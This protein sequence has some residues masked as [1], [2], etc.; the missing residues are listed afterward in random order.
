MDS[1][2]IAFLGMLA[3]FG[4]LLVYTEHVIQSGRNRRRR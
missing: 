3:I 1:L 2:D 4:V